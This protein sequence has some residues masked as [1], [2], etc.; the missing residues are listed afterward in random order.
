[1][2]FSSNQS[3]INARRKFIV[4]TVVSFVVLISI[5][6]LGSISSIPLTNFN[7][8][9]RT[10][11]IP[12][13]Q[14]PSA[15]SYHQLLEYALHKINEDR[16]KFNIS[17][18]KLSDNNT[19]AQLQ[20]EDMLRMRLISHYTTNGMKPYMVY[21]LNGG[22]GYVAQNVG[23]DGFNNSQAGSIN[24]CKNGVYYCSTIDPIKSIDILEHDM[25]YEDSIS[26]W[27]HR[28]N[29]LDKHH[30]YVSIGIAYDGYSFAIVQNF[31][32]NYIQFVKPIIE[33]DSSN[34]NKSKIVISGRILGNNSDD[35]IDSIFIYHD[36]LPTHLIYE[37]HKNDNF[38]DLGKVVA[39]IVKPL[40]P[41]QHYEQ[42]S[43][44][45]L[46]QAGKWWTSPSSSST[47]TTRSEENRQ[48]QQPID[49][50][51]NISSVEKSKGVYTVV[52][53]LRDS[54][55]DTFPVTAYSIFYQ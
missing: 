30:T 47:T 4:I 14:K 18:V 31:E 27:S 6:V 1:M 36:E 44:Y 28:H 39:G 16:T 38:Y 45:T 23:Y 41:K 51:F 33:A 50:Q 8:E 52:V 55:H 13:I 25:I 12:T 48:Q 2:I 15:L 22:K 37:Q 11:I 20:A 34:N 29:I 54:G 40:E 35:S 53:Y 26:N 19:A 42:R 7:P 43:N 49:I 21:T 10:T 5:K 3:K 32:N 17:V 9:Q 46:I 24:K